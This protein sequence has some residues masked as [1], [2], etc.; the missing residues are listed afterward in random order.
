MTK[1]DML[2]MKIEL[3]LTKTATDVLLYVRNHKAWS[4]VVKGMDDTKNDLYKAIAGL[5]PKHESEA[6]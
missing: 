1:Q 2:N 6:L 3:A 5:E 4:E